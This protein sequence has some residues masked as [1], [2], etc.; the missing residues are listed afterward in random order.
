[1]GQESWRGCGRA[2]E[3]AA[4]STQDRPQG[5]TPLDRLAGE[6]EPVVTDRQDATGSAA[7]ESSSSRDSE[8]EADNASSPTGAAAG[9]GEDAGPTEAGDG[10]ADD[11]GTTSATWGERATGGGPQGNY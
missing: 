10:E 1:V 4:V 9:V 6:D 11:T 2:G 5:S 7:D 3:E 8:Y